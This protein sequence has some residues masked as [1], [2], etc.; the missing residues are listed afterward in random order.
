MSHSSLLSKCASVAARYE[1]RDV[2]DNVIISLCKFSTLLNM[3]EVHDSAKC[4]ILY[5]L[6]TIKYS[7]QEDQQNPQMFMSSLA[8]SPGTWVA[9]M[10]DSWTSVGSIGPP[11]H[12]KLISSLLGP[13]KLAEAASERLNLGVVNG[14]ASE[15]L[16][17][18]VVLFTTPKFRCSEAASANF[19]G[20]FQKAGN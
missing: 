4:G 19:W 11:S 17:L 6:M 1:L 3:P 18:G 5:F 7:D 10:E 20:N 8:L 9:N 13:Q 16:N 12:W 15:H 14:S 2:F